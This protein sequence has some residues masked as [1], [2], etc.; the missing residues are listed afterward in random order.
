M[1]VLNEGQQV[2][3]DF[4][5][6][7]AQ[8]GRVMRIQHYAPSF[9]GAG[10]D[11]SYLTLSG[12]TQYIHAMDFPVGMGRYGGEDFKLLEQGHIQYDDRKMFFNPAANFSGAY[13]KIGISGSSVTELFSVIPEGAKVY[14]VQGVDIYKKVYAR[15]LNTGSFPGEF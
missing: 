1:T 6:D 11:N 10:Y 8:S 13:V 14:P 4:S 5:G 3:I 12:T 2:A 15:K 7:V 9:S